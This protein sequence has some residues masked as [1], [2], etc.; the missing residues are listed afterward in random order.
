MVENSS[1]KQLKKL[2]FLK[3]LMNCLLFS[4]VFQTMT[5]KNSFE[6]DIF[7]CDLTW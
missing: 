7:F 3:I 4:F 2:S 5:Y 1:Q 6:F